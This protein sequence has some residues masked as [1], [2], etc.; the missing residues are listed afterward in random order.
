MGRGADGERGA[1]GG[2]DPAEDRDRCFGEDGMCMAD[3]LNKAWP[4][5]PKAGRGA[6]AASGQQA[7]PPLDP[8]ERF[9]RRR[10]DVILDLY[11]QTC[12]RRGGAATLLRKRTI[13]EAKPETGQLPV[14]TLTFASPNGGASLGLRLEMADITKVLIKDRAGQAF[15]LKS[16]SMSA[17][18]A[19]EFDLT[20]KMYPGGMG[21]GYLDR[22]QVG[23]AI[24][25]Y[26]MAER[27]NAVRHAGTHVGVLAFGVGVTE[28]L[29]VARGELERPVHA[30]GPRQ[31]HLLWSARTFGDMFWHDEIAALE[32]AHP[33][34]FTV[35]RILSREDREGCLKGRI[36]A[37]VLAD[38]FGGWHEAGA[39]PRFHA[40]GTCL[41]MRQAKYNLVCAGF[42]W[43]KSALL[44]RP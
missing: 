21:S 1:G 24:D 27:Y 2:A 11:F 17:E 22:V 13:V 42:E 15:D 37:E 35:T 32:R 10:G 9:F 34:R 44:T 5:G 30:G 16:Y 36:D 19:G 4:A 25:I 20:V 26:A 33:G 41:M 43:P 28:A 8:V 6:P 38:V 18:R 23:E 3:G 31:V 14:R 12:R 29:P 7:A 39:E 40:V